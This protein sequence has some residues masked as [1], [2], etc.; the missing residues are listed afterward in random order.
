MFL[1]TAG[2]GVKTEE[3]D[4]HEVSNHEGLQILCTISTKMSKITKQQTDC[5]ASYTLMLQP[6]FFKQTH[7]QFNLEVRHPRCVVE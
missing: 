1:R 4:Q 5:K 6:F 7:I 2:K 3:Q